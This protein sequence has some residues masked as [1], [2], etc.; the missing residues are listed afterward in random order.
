MLHQSLS[1]NAVLATGCVICLVFLMTAAG[2]QPEYAKLDETKVD[3]AMKTKALDLGTKILLSYEKGK[4]Q[5]LGEEA[6]EEMRLGLTIEKQKEAHAAIKNV[7]GAFKSMDYVETWT[8][9]DKSLFIFRFKGN[10]T[11][12]DNK[13]EIRVVLDNNGKLAGLWLKPWNDELQ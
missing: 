7:Y 11:A 1:A 3:S 6:T 12:G 4:Y 5:L 13:P 9:S 10:F 8:N 2:C